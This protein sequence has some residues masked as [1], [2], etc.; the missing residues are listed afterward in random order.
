MNSIMQDFSEIQE[1]LAEMPKDEPPDRCPKCE[2]TDID[3]DS[4]C[5]MDWCNN[6]TDWIFTEKW[7]SIENDYH[8]GELI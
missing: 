7:D 3:W 1:L 8:K 2:S 6:C 5:K 4:D